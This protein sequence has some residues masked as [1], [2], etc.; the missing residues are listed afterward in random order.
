M[1]T[2]VAGTA[3]EWEHASATAIVPLRA[4][5]MPARFRGEL[6]AEGQDA[7]LTVLRSDCSPHRLDRSRRLIDESSNDSVIVQL[8]LGGD[9]VVEQHGRIADVG[10]GDVVMYDAAAPYTLRLPQRN[11]SRLLRLP[12]TALDL[13]P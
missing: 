2:L 8:A 9:T 7:E 12:R 3:A 10:V 6:R 11:V 5:G 1:V 13:A 4:T